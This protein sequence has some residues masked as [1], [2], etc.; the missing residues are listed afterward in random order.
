MPKNQTKTS[1]NSEV[2]RLMLEGELKQVAAEDLPINQ[3]KDDVNEPNE[4]FLN[5]REAEEPEGP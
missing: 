5:N 2:K 4:G 3:K 1:N